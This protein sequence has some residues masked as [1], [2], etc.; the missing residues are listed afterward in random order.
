[1]MTKPERPFSQSAGRMTNRESGWRVNEQVDGN[2]DLLYSELKQADMAH[3]ALTGCLA[4][5]NESFPD[6]KQ[7]QDQTQHEQPTLQ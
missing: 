1:M 5:E 2:R 4:H 6:I 7:E 3:E